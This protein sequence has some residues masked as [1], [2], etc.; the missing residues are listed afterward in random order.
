MASKQRQSPWE[1]AKAKAVREQRIARTREELRGEFAQES[2]MRQ[3]RRAER[4]YEAMLTEWKAWA[5]TVTARRDVSGGI[6]RLTISV[7][8]DMPETINEHIGDCVEKLRSSLDQLLFLMSSR[9]QGK[10]TPQQERQPAFPI[11]LAETPPKDRA[12]RGI[13]LLPPKAAEQVRK[14]Q[15]FTQYSNDP[16][17]S[18][19]AQL[20]ILAERSK[21]RA[22]IAAAVA[23]STDFSMS[24]GL[25]NHLQINHVP[26]RAGVDAP[27]VEVD[28][29]SERYVNLGHHALFQLQDTRSTLDGRD[30]SSVISSILRYV[31]EQVF[32]RLLPEL[33]NIS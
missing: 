3:Y 9:Q 7:A 31:D 24:G 12:W 5:S 8:E 10:L 2:F 13:A 33:K 32:G 30:P 19:L 11:L 26:L 6:V 28:L 4:E 21:H 1:R 15:P 14:M 20:Q 23:T 25:V 18:P 16:A 22:A 29:A 17:E 27:V